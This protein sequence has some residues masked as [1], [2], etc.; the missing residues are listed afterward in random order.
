MGCLFLTATA[1][2]ARGPNPA[3]VSRSPLARHVQRPRE[4][5]SQSGWITEVD[6]ASGKTFYY[7]ERT[8]E[9][10]WEPPQQAQAPPP[11][12]TQGGWVPLVDQ[13]TGKTYYFNEQ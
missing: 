12:A 7:N 10:S 5:F 1:F 9:S 2:T 6:A 13:N 4:L 11:A 8:G 3:S